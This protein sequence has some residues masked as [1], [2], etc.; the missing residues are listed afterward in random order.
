MDVAPARTGAADGMWQPSVTL[1]DVLRFGGMASLG[2]G[3]IHAVAAGAH[4]GADQAV[5]AFCVLAA[6]QIAWGL[7]ALSM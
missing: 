2:A 6:F 1:P 5:T 3:A 7:A 4:S